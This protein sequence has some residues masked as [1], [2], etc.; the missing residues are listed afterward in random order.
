MNGTNGLVE[1]N[2]GVDIHLAA[3]R[4]ARE[5]AV[6]ALTAERQRLVERLKEIDAALAECTGHRGERGPL[7]PRPWRATGE[8]L[9]SKTLG[10]LRDH[11]GSS[12]AEIRAAVAIKPEALSHMRRDGR[13]TTR[14]RAG[15]YR[16][17]ATDRA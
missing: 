8:T 13:V 11:P 6:S 16:Y 14:G 10:F 3:L 17:Y 1:H 2:G 4:Q 9:T 12:W 15:D 5:A 7:K